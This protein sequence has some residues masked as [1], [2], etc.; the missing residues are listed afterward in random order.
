MPHPLNELLTGIRRAT[1]ENILARVDSAVNDGS[2]D[3]N[4]KR[5][6]TG[7]II[8]ASVGQPGV[9]LTPLQLVTIVRLDASGAARNSG[10]VISG[11]PNSSTKGSSNIAPTSETN[12]RTGASVTLLSPASLIIN[13]NTNQAVLIYGTGLDTVTLDYGSPDLTNNIAPVVT[14]TLITLSIHCAVSPTLGA[15]DF[16][17]GAKKFLRYFTITN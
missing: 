9:S 6:D 10:Y 13:P 11:F 15:F 2:G 14:A 16:T 12:T 7:Q 8:R 5:I 4:C 17:I 3:Y 1:T